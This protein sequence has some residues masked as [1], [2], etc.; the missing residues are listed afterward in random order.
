MG[1]EILYLCLHGLKCEVWDL[2][3][4][5]LLYTQGSGQSVCFGL[6]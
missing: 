1:I 3:Q 4:L 5:A 2:A 6:L